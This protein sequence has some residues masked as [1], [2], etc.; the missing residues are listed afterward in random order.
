MPASAY[1][2]RANAFDTT[3][4]KRYILGNLRITRRCIGVACKAVRNDK[5]PG[6]ERRFLAWLATV[7]GKMN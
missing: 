7:S 4:S 5:E 6:K 2:R 1:S 3:E